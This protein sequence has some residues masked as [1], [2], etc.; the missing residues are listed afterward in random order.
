MLDLMLSG[1]ISTPEL[2]GCKEY[3]LPVLHS[4]LRGIATVTATD[5][6]YC[7][8]FTSWLHRRVVG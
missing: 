7:V 6:Q 2:M 3:P 5:R 1:F 8:P 4:L